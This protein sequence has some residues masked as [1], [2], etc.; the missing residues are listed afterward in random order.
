MQGQGW[1]DR[2][3]GLR[4]P[5]SSMAAV[6]PSPDARSFVFVTGGWLNISVV[7]PPLFSS[8]MLVSRLYP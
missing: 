5:L 6:L 3:R 4:G 7:E 8:G 1:G 2:V